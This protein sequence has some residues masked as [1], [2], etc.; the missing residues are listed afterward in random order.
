M[1]NKWHYPNSFHVSIHHIIY[2]ILILIDFDVG[3]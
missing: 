3:T 1:A 2:K